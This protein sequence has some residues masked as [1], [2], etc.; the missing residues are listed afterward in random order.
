MAESVEAGARLV[1]LEHG[2]SFPARRELFDFEEDISDV[3]GTW[4]KPYHFKHVQV[5]PSKLVGKFVEHGSSSTPGEH[6]SYCLVVGN[7]SPR[8]PFR[9]HF[10]PMADQC[11][12]SFQLITGMIA[13]LQGPVAGAVRIRPAP[14]QG[15]NFADE[16]SRR[17]GPQ[18]LLQGGT[19]M[20]AFRHARLI[21]CTYP[22]TTFSEAMATGRPVVLLYP[23][24]VYERHPVASQLLDQ[25]REARIIFHDSGAATSHITAVWENPGSWW[26]SREVSLARDAFFETALRLRCDWLSE[27]ED[28]LERCIQAE[29]PQHLRADLQ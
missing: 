18:V 15:W 23:A 24:E 29:G 26:R 21:V 17:F 9:A 3:R 20:S 16:Y 5:P 28:F 6:A 12:R 22:E 25:M 1:V 2:G 10:Y 11:K 7:E 27:W 8:W 19:L 13:G 14:N 4:F